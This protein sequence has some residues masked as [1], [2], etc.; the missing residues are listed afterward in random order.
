MAHEVITGVDSVDDESVPDQLCARSAW[1]PKQMR[2]TSYI[3]IYMYMFKAFTGDISCA[4]Y[5]HKDV[6]MQI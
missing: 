2:L 6:W 3:I 4:T 1:D 5:P